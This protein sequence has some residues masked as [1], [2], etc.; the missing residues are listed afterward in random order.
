MENSLIP[1]PADGSKPY[2]SS[3]QIGTYIRCPEHYLFSYVLKIKKPPNAAMIQGRAV[4]E[5]IAFDYKEKFK[6]GKNLT[7]GVV[8]DY[9]G[10]V[11]DN[12]FNEVDWE[13]EEEK[14]T[15]IKD[16]AAA[17]LKLYHQEVA[18]DINPLLIEEDVRIGFDNVPYDLKGII[19]LVDLSEEI[20]DF[21]VKKRKPNAADLSEDIQLRTYSAGYRQRFGKPEAG[22][23]LHYLVASKTKPELIALDPYRYTPDDLSRL[24]RTVAYVVKAINSG[25]FYCAHPSDSWICSE[26]WCGYYEIHKELAKYGLDYIKDKYGKT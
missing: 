2:I 21:K 23:K 7:T 10:E 4:H 6:T 17:V 22:V 14:P 5:A 24:F 11:I 20:T 19:D 13:R 1:R 26:K 12:A 18:P 9:F 16:G 25:I 3:S 15:A 8:L